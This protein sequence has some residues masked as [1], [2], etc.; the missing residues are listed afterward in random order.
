MIAR[1]A[2]AYLERA[3]SLNTFEDADRLHTGTASQRKPQEFFLFRPVGRSDIHS[4]M[5]G[6]LHVSETKVCGYWGN[7]H[8]A[9]VQ[10]VSTYESAKALGRLTLLFIF[11]NP[12]GQWQLLTASTDPISNTKFV[13]AIP[14]LATLLQKPWIPDSKPMPA[15]LLSPED[16][17]YPRAPA[18]QRFGEFSWQPS[19][20]TDVVAEIVE[21]AYKDDARLFVEFLS[22]DHPASEKISAGMLWSTGSLWQWR[23]W[24]ISDAGTVSFSEFRSFRN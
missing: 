21:F 7:D 14:K 3:A 17:Q 11:R 22:G 16:G 1:V 9:F 10:T 18:G 23:V 2:Q 5:V 15:K 19:V 13:K 6:E 24:S 8:L 12:Q 20:S 4:A